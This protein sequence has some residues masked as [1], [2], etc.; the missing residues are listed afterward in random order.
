MSACGKTT[1][2]DALARGELPPAQAL[3]LRTHA[4]QCAR[5]RHEL[6]WLESEA[7]LFRQRASRDEVRH[8]WEGV[9][10]SSKRPAV[11][12]R[13]TRRV[14]VSLAASLLLV[15]GLSRLTPAPPHASGGFDASSAGWNA[16]QVS[17]AL[18]SENVGVGSSPMCSQLP[19]G[20]GF[21]CGPAVPA[22]FVASR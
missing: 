17:E 18:S 10:L 19:E 14:L 11:D 3:E 1:S 22:S 16:E 8:L 7:A 5:C 12:P 9:A 6:N 4:A 13:R 21:W 15:A 20:W 2:L